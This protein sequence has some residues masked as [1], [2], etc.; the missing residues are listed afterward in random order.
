MQTEWINALLGGVLI[1]ISVSLMLYWN[2][3]V[4]G[5]SGIINGVLSPLKGDSQWRVLFI[6]GLVLGG[7]VMRQMNSDFFENTLQTP[8]WTVGVAGL[9]VGFGTIMGSGCTSG[10]GVCGISRL[11]PRSLIAT[12]VFMVAGTLAVVL[13]RKL[14]ILL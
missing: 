7:L 11:S 8:M 4:T 5:I 2:G 6:A 13:F 14:G 9:L 12:V 3:R 1:G 10:H